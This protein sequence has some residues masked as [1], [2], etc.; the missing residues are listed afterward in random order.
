MKVQ[1][2]FILSK[3]G[4]LTLFLI[5]VM[6]GTLTSLTTASPNEVNSTQ[7]VTLNVV[8]RHSSELFTTFQAA[9]LASDDSDFITGQTLVVDGGRAMI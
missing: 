3:K 1:S 8:T 4:I 9:F 6:I 7:G 5:F 2:R